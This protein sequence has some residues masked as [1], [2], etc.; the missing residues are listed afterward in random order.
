MHSASGSVITRTSDPWDFYWCVASLCLS[1]V[2]K[3]ALENRVLLALTERCHCFF[4]V[5]SF[6]SRVLGV[7]TQWD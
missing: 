2:G 3:R 1:L 4:W 6:S 7:G 5:Y